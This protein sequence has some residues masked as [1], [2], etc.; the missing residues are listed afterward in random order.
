MKLRI[1][2]V[3]E[4]NLTILES[5]SGELSGDLVL[6]FSHMFCFTTLFLLQAASWGDWRPY[7]P[8]DVELAPCRS[9]PDCHP[10]AVTAG[11]DR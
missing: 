5:S 1:G 6:Q 9:A 7:L 3:D 2:D 8:L 4:Q 10:G 11:A